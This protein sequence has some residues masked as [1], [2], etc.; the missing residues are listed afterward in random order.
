[1][2]NYSGKAEKH[3]W[4]KEENRIEPKLMTGML[5]FLLSFTILI[6]KVISNGAGENNENK[7]RKIIQ[8]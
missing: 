2:R 5:I 6:C 3:Q 1:M 8:K 4:V 7:E